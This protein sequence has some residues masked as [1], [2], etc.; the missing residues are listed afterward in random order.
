[1]SFDFDMAMQLFENLSDTEQELF[2]TAAKFLISADTGDNG[3]H[4]TFAA[5]HVRNIKL[6]IENPAPVQTDL[7]GYRLPLYTKQE[8]LVEISFEC[9]SKNFLG[10]MFQPKKAVPQ[11]A[12]TPEEE[13]KELE[14]MLAGI[15]VKRY[16]RGHLL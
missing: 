1:M 13:E 4:Y 2:L 8:N 7:G 11:K 15:T 16:E 5:L 3:K 14:K 10:T 9:A 6:S 12:L